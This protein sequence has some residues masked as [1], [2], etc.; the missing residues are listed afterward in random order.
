MSPILL[1]IET[2]ILYIFLLQPQYDHPARRRINET[3]PKMTVPVVLSCDCLSSHSR[4]IDHVFLSAATRSAMAAFAWF[5][6][7]CWEYLLKSG[8]F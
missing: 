2:W 8:N 4:F 7:T 3:L 5:L 1:A 6:N